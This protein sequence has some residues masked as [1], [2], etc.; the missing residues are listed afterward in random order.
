MM[1]QK[2]LV[3]LR[4]RLAPRVEVVIGI[5]YAGQPLGS[6][7]V[8]LG[9]ASYSTAIALT[10]CEVMAV[11]RHP[12]L[13][14]AI[15]DPAVLGALARVHGWELYDQ[16][17]RM[18]FLTATPVRQRLEQTLAWIATRAGTVTALSDATSGFGM[19]LLLPVVERDLVDLIATSRET[20]IGTLR[21]LESE[22]LIEC[23]GGRLS[24][25]PELLRAP[26][27]AAKRA[28]QM[29]ERLAERPEHTRLPLSR[30][31][32][33]ERPHSAAERWAR[34]VLHAV[35]ADCDPKTLV[36]WAR[37]AGVSRSALCE[38]CS[39]VH[40]SPRDARDFARVLRAVCRSRDVWEP[41]AIMDFAD[42][43]TLKKVMARA[44]LADRHGGPTPTRDE[45][46]ERQCWIR[47]DTPA[48]H[49]LRMMLS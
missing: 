39:I 35:D 12:F 44:G 48:L 24:L 10:D 21:D 19:R 34:L 13:A 15:S 28:M 27:S 46:I 31:E 41:E 43:R 17:L 6:A 23:R 22:G 30:D 33:S 16:A 49:V 9:T 40:V 8:L 20:L 14:L 5:R 4:Q 29:P 1:L 42:A 38:C 2:G 3:V 26:G 7:A 37:S 47:H 32:H 25:S 36:E 11:K 45:F 18:A